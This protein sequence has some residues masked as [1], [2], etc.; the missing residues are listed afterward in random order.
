MSLEKQI[1]DQYEHRAE[2]DRLY[3]GGY[4][5]R[6]LHER[7]IKI[8]RLVGRFRKEGETIL[9]IGAGHG[10]NVPILLAS[11]FKESGI[12]LNEMLPVRIGN[13]RSR[14]PS[15]CLY[16]GNALEVEFNATFNWVFQSTV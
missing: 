13:I 3:S 12:C 9:E 6:S 5:Q 7:S 2:K 1:T 11:G 8:A 4:A 10:D 14:F 15:I 16:E